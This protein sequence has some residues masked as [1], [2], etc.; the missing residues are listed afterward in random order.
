MSIKAYVDELRLINGEIKRNN[1]Q[2]K[3]L[4]ERIRELESHI[5]SYLKSKEHSGLK[6]NG[7]AV[8]LEN[9]EMRGT[10]KKNERYE[11]TIAYLRSFGVQKPDEVYNNLED[12]R[13][14]EPVEKVKLKFKKIK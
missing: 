10:K 5:T 12:I 1:I 3:K 6:Y 7:T 9:K 11:E 2:N 13:K 8:L 4:R 14:G